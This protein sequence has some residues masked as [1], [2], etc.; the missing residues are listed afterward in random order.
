MDVEVRVESHLL[1][2]NKIPK[3]KRYFG[4][5]FVIGRTGE[6]NTK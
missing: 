2:F 3:K 5:G 1:A 6:K 4:K